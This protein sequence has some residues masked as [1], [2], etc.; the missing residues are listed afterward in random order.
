MGLS[1]EVKGV[2]GSKVKGVGGCKAKGF[3]CRKVE[4]ASRSNVAQT[5]DGEVERLK[6][7]TVGSIP[8]HEPFLDFGPT[9]LTAKDIWSIIPSQEIPTFYICIYLYQIFYLFTYP[10]QKVYKTNKSLACN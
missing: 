3:G 4:N 1:C 10:R 8:L 5:F 2:C 6:K 7:L 9:K